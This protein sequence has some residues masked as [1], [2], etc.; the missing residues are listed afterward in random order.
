[1]AKTT[2]TVGEVYYQCGFASVVEEGPPRLVVSSWRYDGLERRSV[3]QPTCDEPYHYHRFT[4]VTGE[5]D[6]LHSSNPKR[7]YIAS[8]HNASLSMLEK[9]EFIDAVNDPDA[10]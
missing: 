9:S 1:M 5:C 4:C 6:A 3:T 10:G 7:I 2:H 8:A